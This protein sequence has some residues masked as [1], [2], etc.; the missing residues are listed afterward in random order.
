LPALGGTTV[1]VTQE[2]VRVRVH[3]NH[4]TTGTSKIRP[5]DEANRPAVDAVAVDLRSLGWG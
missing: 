2:V 4:R 3:Q 5:T 1:A